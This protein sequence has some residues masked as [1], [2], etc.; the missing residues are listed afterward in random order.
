MKY[1]SEK[2]NKLFDSADACAEA[3]TTHDKE[4]AE[5]EAKQK[6]LADARAARAKEVE[7]LYKDAVEAKKLYNEALRAF[8]KD[9]GSFHATFKNVDPFFSLLDWF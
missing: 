9:Y 1:F 2:L 7:D 4:V 5:K 6:A 3:E 8:I